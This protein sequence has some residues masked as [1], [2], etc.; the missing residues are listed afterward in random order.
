MKQTQTENKESEF[1]DDDSIYRNC[2][3]CG[4][5]QYPFKHGICRICG[6]NNWIVD[7]RKPK[8]SASHN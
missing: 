4:Q 5:N 8:V 3:N 2:I 6:E 7:F 1:D